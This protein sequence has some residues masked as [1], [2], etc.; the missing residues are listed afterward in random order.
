M[1]GQIRDQSGV[2]VASKVPL[3]ELD[4]GGKEEKVE[5]AGRAKAGDSIQEEEEEEEK[6]KGAEGD[7]AGPRTTEPPSQHLS[8]RV[9]LAASEPH[10]QGW[11]QGLSQR[12]LEA[13]AAKLLLLAGV[14]RLDKDLTVGQMQGKFQ[15]QVLP[16][17]GHTVHEDSPDKVAEVLATFLVRNKLATATEAFQPAGVAGLGGGGAMPPWA[18]C[19]TF[20]AGGAGGGQLPPTAGIGIKP[21]GLMP[22]PPP[23][24]LNKPPL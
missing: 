23:P 21:A 18:G 6:K 22:P 14:D 20:P 16:A 10:W 3:E 9:D 5:R 2:L 7:M 17:V 15:M 24:P 4:G 19:A 13:P 8:W 12:F 1:P 11:F